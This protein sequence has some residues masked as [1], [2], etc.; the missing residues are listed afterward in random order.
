MRA[1]LLLGCMIMFPR[2]LLLSVLHFAPFLRMA[3][4]RDDERR[5]QNYYK[6]SLL[7]IRSHD[8]RSGP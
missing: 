3:V 6:I 2:G 5:H 4:V 1:V 8:Y 7:C